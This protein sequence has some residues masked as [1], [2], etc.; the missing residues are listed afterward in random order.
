MTGQIQKVGHISYPY[1][2]ILR[3]PLYVMIPKVRVK[4]QKVML[5]LNVYR[6]LHQ[7][8]NNKAK[9]IFNTNM[10]EQLKGITIETPVDITYQVFYPTKRIIDKMNVIS[11]VSKFTLDAITH[12]ECWYD[13]SDVQIKQE[14]LLPTVYDKNNGRVEIHIKCLPR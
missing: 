9:E 12:H 8:V 7:Q 3:V 2:L 13:D 10:H 14:T 11:I 5:N 6:N 4:D 1:A